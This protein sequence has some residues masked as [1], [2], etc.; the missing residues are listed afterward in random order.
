[1]NKTMSNNKIEDRRRNQGVEKDAMAEWETIRD[2]RRD[3]L[4]VR[5]LR[6][7]YNT[8]TSTVKAVDGVS[9]EI[10]EGEVLG[11]IGESGCGKSA[12]SM[13]LMQLIQ[14][15]GE[16]VGGEINFKGQDL[17]SKSK[18]EMRNIRG[19]EIG[20]VFQ[21]AEEALNPV[22]PVGKQIAEP[23][24]VHEGL[25][26]KTARKRAIELMQRVGIPSPETRVDNYPHE[27][28]GGM[29]QRAVI[30]TALACDPDLLIAD[31]P[32]TNL[33]VT[34]EAQ[35]LDL[36]EELR[37]DFNMSVLFITHD[38]GVAAQ[39]CDRMAVM[40][41]G[42]V[43]EYGPVEDI[44]SD[45][46]HPYTQGLLGSIPDRSSGKEQL[47]SIPGHVPD[48]GNLP[49]GCHF[50]NRCDHSIE[51]CRNID[52]RLTEVSEDH[53]SACIWEDPR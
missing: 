22:F 6:T 26:K 12:T 5:G 8:K 16:I 38:L 29:A 17:L 18:K 14:S 20:I 48:A 44:Y 15:P 27:F 2:D 52:P 25:D 37:D 23:L 46:R 53:Y 30:A 40:Y 36:L 1:M 42:R 4:S 43:V 10:G 19:D 47:N 7:H 32:T 28:S 51:E 9:F 49:S 11:L 50:F 3:L 24:R 35:I 34:I 39:I 31:E 41:A 45:P 33:D 13:S 21:E